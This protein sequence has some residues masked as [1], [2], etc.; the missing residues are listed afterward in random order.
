MEK[1]KEVKDKI[2]KKTSDPINK[3]KEIKDQAMEKGK[4][5]KD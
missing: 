1:G 2:S 5:V 4:R 3:G